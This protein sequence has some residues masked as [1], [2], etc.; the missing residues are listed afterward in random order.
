MSSYLHLPAV[1]RSPPQAMARLAGGPDHP[2]LSGTVRFY[3]TP[4]GVIVWTEVRG[5]PRSQDP[6]ASQIFGFHIHEGTDCAGTPEDPFAGARSH[7]NPG[8][9][10]H[11]HHAGDLPPLFGSGNGCALSLF[12]TDR[13]TVQE[14]TGRT[15][16]L[17]AHPD[18]LTTQP[19]GGAGK[20]IGC[21]VIRRTR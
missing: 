5:L 6:C 8:G 17:H 15:V 16:I 10:A 12:L 9:C 4:A 19:A 14:V 21:G 18:D 7:F 2:N 3:Q 11:P 20:K 1:L 13:F